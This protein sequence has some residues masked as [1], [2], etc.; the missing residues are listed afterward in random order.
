MRG[1]GCCNTRVA[2][3]APAFEPVSRDPLRHT[4]IV[5]ADGTYEM[6]IDGEKKES[7]KLE[8][9]WEFLKPKEIDDPEDKKPEDWADD[10]MMDDPEDKKPEDWGSEPE[11]IADPEAE[12]PEDWDEED[13]G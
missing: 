4:A 1:E 13:D 9:D 5:N 8:E 6:Q 3:A 7:G 10:S 2:A 11:T 12:Q